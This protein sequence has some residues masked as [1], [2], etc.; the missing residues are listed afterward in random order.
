MSPGCEKNFSL[1]RMTIEL[2]SKSWHP[3]D[4]SSSFVD[5]KRCHDLQQMSGVSNNDIH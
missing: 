3:R 2:V 1:M 5:P 4:T